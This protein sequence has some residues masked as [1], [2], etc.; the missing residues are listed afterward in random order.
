MSSIRKNPV[1]FFILICIFLIGKEKLFFISL[2]FVLTFWFYRVHD[3][4]FLYLLLVAMICCIPRGSLDYPNAKEGKVVSLASSYA[5]VQNKDTKFILYCDEMLKL[6]CIYTFDV[7]FEKVSS[8]SSFYGFDFENYCKQNQIYYCGKPSAVRL[9]KENVTFRRYLQNKIDS[10]TDESIQKIL[11]RTV[12]NVRDTSLEEDWLLDSGFS[13]RGILIVLEAVLSRFL[14]KRKQKTLILA[15]EL[16]LLFAYRIPS[17]ILLCLIGDILFFSDLDYYEKTVIPLCCLLLYNPLCIYAFSFQVIAFL[18]LC[19]LFSKQD[20][21]PAMCFLMIME[22]LS[23]NRMNPVRSLFFK[24]SLFY[25]G[26]LW[27]YGMITVMSGIPYAKGIL[28]IGNS[29]AKIFVLFD[30]PGSIKGVGIVFFI[31]FILCFSKN[32]YYFKKVYVT[33]LVFQ[34][35]GLFHPFMEI[36]VINVGQ[37]DS[38]YVKGPFHIKDI[39]VDTGK[40]SAFSSVDTFLQAKGVKNVNTMIITHSDDDHAGNKDVIAEKYKVKKII[41]EHVEVIQEWPFVIYDLNTVSNDNANQSS[42]MNYF[43][44]NGLK[45]LLCGDGDVES[46]KQILLQYG[47]LDVDILKAGHHGSASS[48]S[49]HFL[50][51]VQPSVTLFSAGSP[52]LYHHPSKEVTERMEKRHIPYLNTYEHGDVTILAFPFGNVLITSSGYVC[53]LR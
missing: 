31:L 23:Y 3:H 26:I 49:E 8:R 10:V 45:I 39:L 14:D 25:N 29:V 53:L 30:L 27:F 47:N 2:L 5:I 37:G 52:D 46:E 7:K 24:G 35:L 41:E 18:R 21:F 51:T 16:F 1:L 33:L 38:I 20:K 44:F 34:L 22:S 48:S 4:S 50:D 15:A 6:D 12:L 13:F 9:K 32:R 43:S 11:Y 40:P 42:I 28:T 17:V 19:S 36:S